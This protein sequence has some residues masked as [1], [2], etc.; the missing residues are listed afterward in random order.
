M[1]RR[2]AIFGLGSIGSRYAQ[3]LMQRP[4]IEVLAF[5]TQRHLPNA[6]NVPETSDWA[7]LEAWQPQVA[8]IANPTHLHIETAQASVERGWGVFLEK[9]IGGSLQ[10]L[11]TLVQE[12]QTRQL[13]SYVAY[14]LRFHPVVHALKAALA[15][16]TVW[17]ARLRC[18]SYLPE[19]RPGRDHRET[20]SA[21]RDTGGGVILDLSHEFDLAEYLC[22][23]ITAIDGNAARRANITIDAEDCADAVAQCAHGTATIHVDYFSRRTERVIDV[24]TDIGSFR[25]DLLAQ[26]LTCETGQATRTQ[27]FDTSMDSLYQEQLA[28]FLA[29]C[30]DGQ[31]IMNNVPEASHLF[32]HLMSFR[33]RAFT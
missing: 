6:G 33:E 14:V 29:R 32:R 13:P 5:R 28:Y 1:I 16:A 4:G 17:H 2:V 9:P 21:R 20:Y 25:A 18:T 10:G 3:W 15:H 23:P 31:P 12:I 22:G 24:D 8:V 26:T 27:T 30:A 11:D 7:V 19:W